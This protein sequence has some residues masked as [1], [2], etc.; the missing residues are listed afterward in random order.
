M[1][2]KEGESFVSLFCSLIPPLLYRQMRHHFSPPQLPFS[3]LPIPLLLP[4]LHIPP[5]HHSP[6]YLSHL[7]RPSAPSHTITWLFFY[8]STSFYFFFSSFFSSSHFT[9]P[10]I[11]FLLFLLIF[12][13]LSPLFYICILFL[14]LLFFPSPSCSFHL[15]SCHLFLRRPPPPS[16]SPGPPRPHSHLSLIFLLLS[17]LFLLLLYLL[18]LFL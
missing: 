7:P 15:S 3:S 5:P 18:L 13:L 6:S 1:E 11:S 17:I 2:D 9:L 16:H 8:S 10:C 4:T 12:F 14:S